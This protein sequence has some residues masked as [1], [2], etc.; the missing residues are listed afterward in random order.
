M[1]R[2]YAS[3]P[4]ARFHWA[5]PVACA[6]I[7]V[8]TYAP[9]LSVPMLPDDY[10]QAQLALDYGPPS[11]WP[12]LAADALYRC[13]ATSIVLTWLLMSAFG[14][15]SLAFGIASIALHIAN[16][17]VLY[18]L[19]SIRAIGWKL[20]TLAA[21]VFAI[22]GRHHEAVVWFAAIP[23]LFVFFFGAA[24]IL[25]WLR[26]LEGGLARRRDYALSLAAFVLALLSKE[27]AVVIVPAAL[28]FAWPWRERALRVAAALAPFALLAVFY[29]AAIFAARQTHHHFN[30]GTFSLEAPFLATLTASAGRGFY[31]WGTSAVIVLFLAR[32]TS[33][34]L[35]FAAAWIVLGLLPYSF[36]TYMGS[37]PSRHHYLASAGIAF[38]TAEAFRVVRARYRSPWLVPALLSVF[39]IHQAGYL[40]IVKVDAFAERARPIESFLDYLAHEPRRPV[41]VTCFPVTVSE[42]QRAAHFRRGEPE[43]AIIPAT[44]MDP[45]DGAPTFCYE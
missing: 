2:A 11:G 39:L 13:R 12:A 19:G 38:V 43:A 17:A 34:I 32:R 29:I 14:L 7:A 16:C 24:A 45:P 25:F 28:L 23:E 42:A 27:S 30:D 10:L 9:F 21:L 18:S 35:P 31:I 37:V 22:R 36:L 20:S 3:L 5:V 26:W 6:V 33:A 44:K 15:S 8:L 1:V 40:W 41:Y 4:A